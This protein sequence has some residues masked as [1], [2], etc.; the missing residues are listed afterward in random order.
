MAIERAFQPQ[1]VNLLPDA[2]AE[3]LHQRGL[4]PQ[5]GDPGEFGEDAKFGYLQRLGLEADAR[6]PV[7]PDFRKR[8]DRGMG[9][10]LCPE[11]IGPP[12]R[13]DRTMRKSRAGS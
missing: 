13:P 9:V 1:S 8:T 2:R 3:Q 10:F 12:R 5:R 7:P 4:R 6:Q 11:D